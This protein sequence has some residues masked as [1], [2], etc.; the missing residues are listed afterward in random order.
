MHLIPMSI[1]WG[2]NTVSLTLNDSSTRFNQWAFAF[3]YW[4]SW[5]GKVGHWVDND[6]GSGWRSSWDEE[7]DVPEFFVRTLYK[8]VGGSTYQDKWALDIICES[9]AGT[10]SYD[11]WH[12]VQD[13]QVQ[14]R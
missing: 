4:G 14:F 7:E 1:P 9:G 13:E 5:Q 3:K 2:E 12:S 11:Y 6:D 8:K 10:D